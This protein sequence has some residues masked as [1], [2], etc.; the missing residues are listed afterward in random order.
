[1]KKEISLE[2]IDLEVLQAALKIIE[3]EN[4]ALWWEAHTGV[5]ALKSGKCFLKGDVLFIL[6]GKLEEPGFLKREFLERIKKLPQWEKSRYYCLNN[7][8]FP[9][10]S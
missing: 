5:G 8:L 4:G 10:E 1:M 9:S 7:N 6:P 3:D 2:G